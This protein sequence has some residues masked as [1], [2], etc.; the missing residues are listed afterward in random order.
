VPNIN[1]I[2]LILS[3]CALIYAV[4][5][6]E[7]AHGYTALKLGDPTAKNSGRLTLNPIP[8]LDILGSI[9]LPAFLLMSG[10]SFFIGWAKPVPVCADYLKDPIKDMMKVA[11]AGPLTNFT[12]AFIA[13][14]ALKGLTLLQI[15][16]SIILK[17]IVYYLSVFLYF[18]IQINVV[19]GI[20][21]LLPIPP[22]DGSKVLLNFLPYNLQEKFFRFESYGFI[23]LIALVYFGF[24]GK[25]LVYVA[26][27][28]IKF[29]L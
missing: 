14:L 11:L 21:N 26:E 28:I 9:L 1:T 29:L 20:F 18:S 27:P 15:D 12:I 17:I 4:I 3:F 8:H 5:F 7:I 23:F 22:L 13:S 19:L 10:S 24:L 2:E 6:H 16:A 25:I